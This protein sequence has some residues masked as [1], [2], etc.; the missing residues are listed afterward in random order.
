M[1]TIVTLRTLAECESVIERGL[2]TFVEVGQALMEIRERRLYREQYETFEDYC[3]ERWGL[4]QS[5]VYQMMDATRV[6]EVL[7]SSTMVELP[8]PANERQAR[9]LVPLLRQDEAKVIEVW[10]ELREQYGEEVTAARVK[11]LVSKRLERIVRE[12]QAQQ[13]PTD[14]AP[15]LPPTVDL[16]LGDFREVLADIPDSSVDLIFTDPPYPA[17]YL[18]LWKDLA[19]FA[20]RVLKPGRLLVAYSGQYHL[21]TIMT[22]LEARLDYVWLGAVILPGSH[23]QVQQRYVRNG[24]KPLLFYARPPYTPTTWFEDCY[25]SDGVEKTTHEWQQS[26]GCARYY[27]ERLT[28]PGAVVVDPFIGG[29]TTAVAARE[30]GR[31]IIGAEIDRQAMAAAIARLQGSKTT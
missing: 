27:I 28:S 30:L 9:E 8:L 3:R 11:N 25:T 19:V 13:K 2:A 22:S 12:R 1:T 14:P 20:A 17:E 26:I 31:T 21:P 5:R 10:R 29:G 15:T 24:V 23:N 6:V 7:K 18:P 4:G 16:R